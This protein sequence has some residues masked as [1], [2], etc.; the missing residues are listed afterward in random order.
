MKSFVPSD[1]ITVLI[2]L[3]SLAC[4][5][6]ALLLPVFTAQALWS[7]P[8]DGWFARVGVAA[9]VSTSAWQRGSSIFLAMLPVSAMAYGL[10]RVRQCLQGFLRQEIFT[11]ST[12]RHLRGFA[13]AI[14]AAA[15]LGLVMPALIG[16][17]LTWD[18][19]A[20]GRTLSLALHSNDLLMGLMAGIVWLIAVVFARA[21]EL[22]DG[23]AQ[24]V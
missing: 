13:S 24:I 5:L 19:P 7:L 2:R 20:G 15:C 23:H 9:P 10:I 3:L 12:V 6:L 14:F 8:S 4:L 22:A 1:S 21:V 11:L 17:V 18:A 16:V